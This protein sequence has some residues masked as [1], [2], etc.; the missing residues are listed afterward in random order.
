MG[1]KLGWIAVCWFLMGIAY[2]LIGFV[3][4][5]FRGITDGTAATLVASSNM[6][7]YPGTLESVLI[8]PLII[9]FIPAAVGLVATAVI[10]RKK[11]KD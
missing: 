9:W 7:N 6:T 1:K 5:T 8:M 10:L 4:S 3:H 11:D 2:A